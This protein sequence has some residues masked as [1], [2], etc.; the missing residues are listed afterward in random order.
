MLVCRLVALFFDLKCVQEPKWEVHTGELDC[1][2]TVV[3]LCVDLEVCG[4]IPG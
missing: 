3:Q 1:S 2:G 4:S